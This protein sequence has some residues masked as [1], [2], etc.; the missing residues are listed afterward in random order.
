LNA[1]V[2]VAEDDRFVERGSYAVRADGR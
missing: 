1:L 2:T